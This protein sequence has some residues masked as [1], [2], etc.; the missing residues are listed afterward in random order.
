[1]SFWNFEKTSNPALIDLHTAKSVSYEQLQSGVEK[2]IQQLA[3][4]RADKSLGLI[5]IRNAVADLTM[6]LAALQKGDA[7]LLLDAALNVSLRER[8]ESVYKPDWIFDC[9]LQWKNIK[10]VHS[11]IHPELAVLL[12]TSGSTGN[13]KLVRLS[14]RNLQSNAEAIA[15]YLKINSSDRPITTLSPAYSYGLSVINSHL[16]RRSTLL[17]TD[18]SIVQPAFWENFRKYEA[19]SFAGVPYLYQ[20]LHRLR[21]D[22]M[23][24][25]SLRYFTQAGGRLSLP[26]AKYFLSVAYHKSASFIIMYGQTE[27]TARISYLPFEQADKKLSSIGVAIPGGEL[28]IDEQS[29]ELIYKGPNVMMG[30]AENR[31]DLARGDEQHGSLHTGDMAY[32]DEDGYFWIQGR[33]KRFIKIYGLRMNLDDLEKSLEQLLETTVA[34][35]GADEQLLVFVEQK[36]HPELIQQIRQFLK[37]KYHI[38]HTSI[39]VLTLSLLPRLENGK[40]DYIT[41]GKEGSNA[42]N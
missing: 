14:Y 2:R 34:C 8:L 18:E 15:E 26:L 11:S 5:Y 4:R 37:N 30:Y 16:L 27:A 36:Q 20:M 3:H 42:G 10:S 28:H 29:G 35:V 19:T 1:M 21:F 32:C 13:P 24:L 38:H 25:P 33:M 6:Y 9:E 12:S 41:L 23:E 7:V 22:R 40:L 31:E 17:L 39:K